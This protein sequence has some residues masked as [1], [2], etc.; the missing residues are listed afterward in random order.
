MSAAVHGYISVLT[1][2][3]TFGPL[4]ISSRMYTAENALKLSNT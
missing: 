2:T 4:Q 1:G 3:K